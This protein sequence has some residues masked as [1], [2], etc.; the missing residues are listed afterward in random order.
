MWFCSKSVPHNWI[1]SSKE[2][3]YIHMTETQK[4]G[5]CKYFD[6][7][8]FQKIKLKRT[9]YFR[10]AAV[11]NET[12]DGN[13]VSLHN[14]GRLAVELHTN[15][16]WDYDYLME[17]CGKTTWRFRIIQVRQKQPKACRV[18]SWYWMTRW[19]NDRW[20]SV[21]VYKRKKKL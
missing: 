19:L 16:C 6:I 2:H 17:R 4:V 18:I 9:L 12:K 5:I 1:N 13:E 21:F 11:R 8:S 15:I 10:K 3:V 14:G 20:Y 7:F